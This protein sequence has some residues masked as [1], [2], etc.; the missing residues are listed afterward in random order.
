MMDGREPS[1]F[2]D[3][4]GFVFSRN[5]VVYRQVNRSYENQYRHLFRSGLHDNLV[6][7]NWLIPVHEVSEPPC[8]PDTA[9]AVV[10]PNM[11]PFLSYPYEWTFTQL[12]DAALLTLDIQEQALRH[13]MTLKDATAFNI[14]FLNCRP[15]FIDTLSF[16][17]VNQGPAW[18]AYRQF[19]EHFLAPLS[20]MSSLDARMGRLL[21]LHHDG[22]PVELACRLL[23]A[24]FFLRLSRCLHLGVHAWAQRKIRTSE[25]RT[26]SASMRE[27]FALV[28]SLRSAV[29][30]LKWTPEQRIWR[31]Y[32]QDSESYSASAQDAKLINISRFLEQIK[33]GVVWDLGCNTGVY[34]RM[35]AAAGAKVVVGADYDHACVDLLYQQERSSGV[36]VIFPL[37]VDLANPSPGIGWHNYERSSFAARGPADLILALA[38]VHHWAF[39]ANITFVMMRDFLRACGRQLLI[40]FVPKDDPMVQRLLRNRTDC[41]PDYTRKHFEVIFSQRYEIKESL[42]LAGSERWLY[43]MVC[44]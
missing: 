39:S 35:A 21:S 33:P 6:T 38:V 27:R 42:S 3:P 41:F 18:P 14:Q 15:V 17:Q 32:Y 31:D 37:L 8:E 10:R 23:P 29:D 20:L 40:E 44:R 1:S 22:I 2:R 30:G 25:S 13:A 16:E 9:L 43:H 34:S 11:I 28:D 19:C 5:G 24:R 36:S 12:K 7:R 4:A 26:Y